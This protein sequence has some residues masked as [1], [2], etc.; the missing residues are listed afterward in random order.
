VSKADDVRSF[1]SK[2]RSE[3]LNRLVTLATDKAE[4]EELVIEL[5][6]ADQA[7]MAV[8]DM[9]QDTGN[10]AQFK[11]AIDAIVAY[12]QEIQ[13]P[14]TVDRIIEALKVGKFRGGERGIELFVHKSIRNFLTGTGQSTKKIK[15]VNGLI[16]LF[17]WSDDMFA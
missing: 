14:S 2:R 6:K 5:G 7:L 13:H 4:A 12:L 8:N 17:E 11:T 9:A 15:E 16:G 10:F 1:L 3:I